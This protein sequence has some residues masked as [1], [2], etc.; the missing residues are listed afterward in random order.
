MLQVI[1]H[2]AGMK[3][4]TVPSKN[5][6]RLHLQ[7]NWSLTEETIGGKNITS[8]LHF[9]GWEDVVVILLYFCQMFKPYS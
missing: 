8:C 9:L 5:M 3:N 7:F 6:L 2:C 1:Y 4:N